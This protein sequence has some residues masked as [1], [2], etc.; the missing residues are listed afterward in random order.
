MRKI[1]EAKCSLNGM[2][3]KTINFEKV[4]LK[5]LEERARRE[6]TTVSK[7]VNMICRGVVLNDMKYHTEMSKMHYLKFQ[8]HQFMKEQAELVQL[9]RR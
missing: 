1:D 4:V 8:E 3:V 2:A 6:N 9:E 7:F 5:F